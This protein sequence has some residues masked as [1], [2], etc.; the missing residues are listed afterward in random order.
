MKV[1]NVRSEIP[2]WDDG[3]KNGYRWYKK[4]WWKRY[5]RKKHIKDYLH[6]QK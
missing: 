2:Y 6:Y 4:G 3:S 5:L 1:P